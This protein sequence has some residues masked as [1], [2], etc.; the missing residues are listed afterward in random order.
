MTAETPLE[1][2]QLA[3][4]LKADFTGK[5]NVTEIGTPEEREKKFLSR[6][7][8][9]FAIQHLAGRNVDEADRKA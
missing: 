1:I 6:A 3:E 9:A 5:L 7:L 2:L 4:R 8:A